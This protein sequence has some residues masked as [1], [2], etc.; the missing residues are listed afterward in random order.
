MVT[1]PAPVMVMTSPLPTLAWPPIERA[2]PA[3]VE[4]APLPPKVKPRL[5]L[6][7]NV[8]VVSSVPPLIVTAVLLS[9]ASGSAQAR[10]R[11]HDQRAAVDGNAAGEGVGAIE[12]LRK[13]ADVDRHAARTR[14]DAG[15]DVVGIVDVV[16]R[17]GPRSQYDI[18]PRG[19]AAHEPADLIREAVHVERDPGGIRQR[20]QRSVRQCIGDAGLKHAGGDGRLPAVGAD[21]GSKIRTLVPSTPV[22]FRLPAPVMA[23][24]SVTFVF[25][26]ATLMVAR[27]IAVDGN[28]LGG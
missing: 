21:G 17:Q 8:E 27:G 1:F 5:T 12:S 15:E 16:Y 25:E 10:L 13:G 6:V 20:Q 26:A 19:S 9:A 11:G 23:P 2:V 3:V 28:G 22:T 7:V 18:S 24:L 4:M 14:D